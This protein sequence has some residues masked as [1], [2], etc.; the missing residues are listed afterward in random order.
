[1]D[2]TLLQRRDA[3]MKFQRDYWEVVEIVYL[4]K[5]NWQ[6]N[7]STLFLV[8]SVTSFECQERLQNYLG[9][10]KLEHML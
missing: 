9:A 4:E 10:V 8:I 3:V 6:L 5:L 1:M 2:R 7:N